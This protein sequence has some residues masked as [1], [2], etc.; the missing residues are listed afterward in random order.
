ML[1][2][3]QHVKCILRPLMGGK[4]DCTGSDPAVARSQTSAGLCVF[5][6]FC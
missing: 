2:K 3:M 6:F 1:R 4:R 5:F